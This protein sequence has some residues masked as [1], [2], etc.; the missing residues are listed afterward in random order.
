MSASSSYSPDL[1]GAT[2][3]SFRGF[4][5]EFANLFTSVGHLGLLGIGSE[6]DTTTGWTIS[7]GLIAAISFCLG[8]QPA[9]SASDGDTA[10]SRW[11]WTHIGIFLVAS[12]AATYLLTYS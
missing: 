5:S 9:A 2:G 6:I 8:R 10:T 12:G 1:D 11:A 3:W 7:A 4:K